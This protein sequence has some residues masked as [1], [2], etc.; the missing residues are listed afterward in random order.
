MSFDSILGRL[1]REV[2]PELMDGLIQATKE[3]DNDK[4]QTLCGPEA[5]AIEDSDEVA[6]ETE[7][8]YEEEVLP[9]FYMITWT[10]I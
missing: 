8:E 9:I 10:W 1:L 2:E 3:G 7:D 4:F 6:E 5:Q